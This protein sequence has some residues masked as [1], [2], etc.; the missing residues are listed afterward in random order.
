MYQVDSVSLHPPPKLKRVILRLILN[1]CGN[2]R[3]D[4]TAPGQG[5]MTDIWD[6][7]AETLISI[8]AGDLLTIEV[9]VFLKIFILILVISYY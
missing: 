5:S 7:F 9:L 3:V 8:K 6:N 4:S 1:K 2:D